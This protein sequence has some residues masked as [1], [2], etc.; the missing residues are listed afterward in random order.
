MATTR[1]SAGLRRTFRSLRHRPY[2]IY[3]A[4]QFLSL[5]GTWM[6]SA[7]LAWLVYDLTG[8]K[9]MLGFVSLAGSIPTV[10]L[11]TWGGVLADRYPRRRILVACQLGLAIQ[12]VA[13]SALVLTEGVHVAHLMALAAALGLVSGIE[14]PT[15]QAFVVEMVGREDLMNAIAL[16]SA[17]FHA[18]RIL[19]PALAGVLIGAVGPGWCFLANGLSYGAIVAAL[20]AMRLT[21]ASPRRAEGSAWSLA[22]EG[23]RVVLRSPAIVTMLALLLVVGVFGWSY[24]VLMPAIARD[25][26]GAG[27]EGYGALMSA[28]AVGS[29]V[30]ALAVA[31][32]REVRDGRLLI[33]GSAL[34][35]A[36]AAALLSGTRRYAV[37]V[38]VLPFAG[39]A[40][41]AFFSATNTLVQSAAPDALR[42]R[43]MGVYTFVFSAM[44]PL[45]ALIAG[46]LAEAV[47]STITIRIGAAVCAAAALAALAWMPR[48]IRRC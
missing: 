23:F 32:L 38:A 21:G 19:G 43:V 3:F 41:T 42:G 9:A 26:L 12:A 10:L 29:V 31:S 44:M 37:A 15:R 17:V 24:V 45:G 22:A 34:L 36:A 48:D 33:A 18:A 2:R 40:L 4:G 25:D 30:G 47:G 16:N 13:L 46:S 11:S 5:V 20:L 27:P 14:M 28:V 7:A 8:S 6:Q 1:A 35:F 39:F